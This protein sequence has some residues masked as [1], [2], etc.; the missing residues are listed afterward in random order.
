MSEDY[1][2]LKPLERGS[3]GRFNTPSYLSPTSFR[4]IIPRV[5]MLTSYIQSVTVPTVTLTSMEIAPFK[6]LPRTQVPSGLD[7]GDQIIVTFS[8][9]ENMEN[10][11]EIYDWMTSIV[12]SEENAANVGK[13]IDDYSEIIL[14]VYSNSKR[15][16]RKI[17]Y[18]NAYPVSLS[19]FEF[20][21][22]AQ[23][24]E[25]IVVPVTFEYSH[26]TVELL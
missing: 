3:L 11:K 22:G 8:V 13:N 6:G 15:M 25:P 21:S 12:P 7:L 10:W 17:T 2:T 26:M 16:T 18:H 5:P 14:L 19:S 24:I 9:D 1:N 4:A 23:T 20:N